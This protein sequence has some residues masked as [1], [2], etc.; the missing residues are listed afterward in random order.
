MLHAREDA[1]T[2]S[3]FIHDI[4]NCRDVALKRTCVPSS[5]I[6]RM[7]FSLLPKRFS[8]PR[9]AAG[10]IITF[11]GFDVDLRFCK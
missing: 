6:I 7:R 10:I 8:V 3:S 9:I 11:S 5:E 1:A 4:H 2:Y